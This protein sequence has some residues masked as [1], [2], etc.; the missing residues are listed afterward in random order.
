MGSMSMTMTMM[1]VDVTAGAMMVLGRWVMTAAGMEGC[2]V[3]ERSGRRTELP[4]RPAVGG[5]W[6][7][8]IVTRTWMVP[9]WRGCLIAFRQHC[10]FLVGGAQGL[11][12]MQ[13]IGFRQ[14]PKMQC[15]G[16]RCAEGLQMGQPL[17]GI[18][19]LGAQAINII[20]HGLKFGSY[21]AYDF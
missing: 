21:L 8:I 16:N 12:T 9:N 10:E 1:I 7:G 6:Y 14:I 11:K 5:W 2:L 18:R 3:V 15:P 13:K 17:I 4:W 19:K 20:A